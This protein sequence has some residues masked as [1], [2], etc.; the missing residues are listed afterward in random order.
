MNL[1]DLFED[2]N[3]LKRIREALAEDIGERGDVTSLSL[4]PADTVVTAALVAREACVVAGT[5]VAARVFA[6]VDAAVRT[7]VLVPDGQ[8]A[9]RGCTVMRMRGRGQAILAGERTALNFMQRMCGVATLTRRFVEAVQGRDV[10]I[11]DTRKTTPTLRPFEKYAVL[12]GGGV[13]HRM[14]LFDRVLIKDNHRHLWSHGH[15]DRL[16]LAVGAARHQFP[17]VPIEVEVESEE[18]LRSALRATPDWVLLDN[19]PP[20]RLMRCVAIVAGRCKTEASGGIT[21]ENVATVAASGVDAI[22]LGCLTHSAG[23]VDLSLE[24]E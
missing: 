17:N 11:L 7:H 2:P 1:P 15:A 24:I 16:D 3:V 13:N 8:N 18:E 19:M 9:E 21:L 14:G 12:C 4:V 5:T 10:E 6:E 23:S 22:S 20:D